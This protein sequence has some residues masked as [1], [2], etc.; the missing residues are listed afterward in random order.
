M[1]LSVSLYSLWDLSRERHKPTTQDQI[2]SSTVLL[3]SIPFILYLILR[4]MVLI[5]TDENWILSYDF[6]E[7]VGGFPVT[8]WPWQI[9]ASND[10]RWTFFR[11]GVIN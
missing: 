7:E 1:I 5:K 8:N 10:N 3:I 6:M 2:F 11:A 4:I 9:D